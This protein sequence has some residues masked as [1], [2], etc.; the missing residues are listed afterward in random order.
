MEKILKFEF[1]VVSFNG[2]CINFLLELLLQEI[3]LIVRNFSHRKESDSFITRVY[4]Q[5]KILILVFNS[6]SEED[7]EASLTHVAKMKSETKRLKRN[8]NEHTFSYD[9]CICVRC[10]CR[11]YRMPENSTFKSNRAV[12]H[13][14]FFNWIVNAPV[15]I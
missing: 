5:V 9:S 8:C 14:K 12:F 4:V 7:Q 15:I 6:K 3:L 1:F 11:H 2:F 13:N 10:F